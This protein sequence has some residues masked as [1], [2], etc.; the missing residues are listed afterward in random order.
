MRKIFDKNGANNGIADDY[1]GGAQIL[2]NELIVGRDYMIKTVGD[3]DWAAVGATEIDSNAFFTCTAV[4]SGTGKARTADGMTMRMQKLRQKNSNNTTDSTAYPQY[5]SWIDDR[6]LTSSRGTLM[7]T[8][9]AFKDYFVDDGDNIT[10]YKM[11]E[12]PMLRASLSLQSDDISSTDVLDPLSINYATS[13][14]YLDRDIVTLNTFNNSYAA[15]DNHNYYVKK[16]D[17]DTIQLSN[18]STLTDLVGFD[19][20]AKSNTYIDVYNFEGNEFDG[21]IALGLHD[22]EFVSDGDG[23]TITN[24]TKNGGGIEDTLYYIKTT[25]WKPKRVFLYTDQALT[26]LVL[27]DDLVWDTNYI[28]NYDPKLIY[29]DAGR[30][31]FNTKLKDNELSFNNT[32][33][34]DDGDGNTLLVADTI[35]YLKLVDEEVLNFPSNLLSLVASDYGTETSTTNYS[36]LLSKFGWLG[37]FARFEY[38]IYHDLELTNQVDLAVGTT[39]GQS[40]VDTSVYPI[41]LTYQEGLGDSTTINIIDIAHNGTNLID[42]TVYTSSTNTAGVYDLYKDINLTNALE[43]SDITEHNH[44]AKSLLFFSW[45]SSGYTGNIQYSTYDDEFIGYDT[46]SYFHDVIDKDTPFLFKST[47][48]TSKIDNQHI[49]TAGFLTTDTSYYLDDSNIYTDVG[50]TTLIDNTVLDQQIKITG[51]YDPRITTGFAHIDKRVLADNADNRFPN[52]GTITDPTHFTLSGE[53]T[54]ESWLDLMFDTW[55]ISIGHREPSDIVGELLVRPA[56]GHGWF[57]WTDAFT[58]Q[59]DNNPHKNF[60]ALHPVTETNKWEYKAYSPSLGTGI[61]DIWHTITDSLSLFDHIPTELGIVDVDADRIEDGYDIINNDAD[62]EINTMYKFWITDAYKGTYHWPY[63]NRIYGIK[64]NA[65]GNYLDG[66]SPWIFFDMI[67]HEYTSY[68]NPYDLTSYNTELWHQNAVLGTGRMDTDHTSPIYGEVLEQPQ[69]L[70]WKK[71][72]K[73]DYAIDDTDTFIGSKS[74]NDFAFTW[75]KYKSNSKT[76]TTPTALSGEPTNSDYVL[77]S[78]DSNYPT[79]DKFGSPFIYIPSD[80]KWAG[81]H[82]VDYKVVAT[83]TTDGTYAYATVNVGDE[84]GDSRP[85]HPDYPNTSAIA[86]TISEDASFDIDLHPNLWNE[87]EIYPRYYQDPTTLPSRVND[88]YWSQPKSLQKVTVDNVDCYLI[89]SNIPDDHTAT[90]PGF[91]MTLKYYV[92]DT[93]KTEDIAVNRFMLLPIEQFDVGEDLDNV[94]YYYWWNESPRTYNL[95]KMLDVAQNNS[96][97]TDLNIAKIENTITFHNEHINNGVT[98]SRTGWVDLEGD[99]QIPLDIGFTSVLNSHEL[100]DTTISTTATTSDPALFAPRDP[101]KVDTA[102]TFYPAT[103]GSTYLRDFAYK[104]DTIE[105]VSPGNTKYSHLNSSNVETVGAQIDQDHYWKHWTS[106]I[107]SYHDTAPDIDITLNSNG[108]ITGATHNSSTDAARFPQPWDVLFPIE[109]LDDEYTTPALTTSAL[110]DVWDTEDQWTDQGYDKTKYWP[111]HV[112]PASAEVTMDQPSS[113]TM[114]QSG[115]KYVKSAGFTKW[116]IALDYPPMSK[117]DFAPFNAVVQAVRGQYTPLYLKLKYNGSNILF[118][119]G[120]DNSTTKP[121]I[122]RSPYEDDNKVLFVEGFESNE[123][124]V[125]KQGEVIITGQDNGSIQTALHDVKSN[126]FGEAKVR[127]AY[128]SDSIKDV[129]KYIYKNPSSA[130]VTLA[131]DS[132]TYSVDTAGFYRIRVKFTLDDWK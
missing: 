69:L 89:P 68:E 72:I 121:R 58:S 75:P 52:W 76:L 25:P 131:Q 60:V 118:N 43:L 101:G 5:K 48:T 57:N 14:G 104:V 83:T 3:T 85:W 96:T 119:F 1:L 13:H 47:D 21:G 128:P 61:A 6:D 36:T 114:S 12:Q 107:K 123:E 127:L 30:V 22:H 79:V 92:D 35:Y 97:L 129:G 17:D 110:E 109:S 132:F 41:T 64:T 84:L 55:D 11:W 78:D 65:N 24:A 103:S 94:D 93:L 50:T 70:S 81:S 15:L 71:P 125:F 8:V 59:A 126:A 74:L 19:T 7:D 95:Y 99:E 44:K 117:D 37:A 88:M 53:Y 42:T 77:A 54:N 67:D 49:A 27:H 62:Y 124:N 91:M 130:V 80:T 29:A 34:I 108:Y 10:T 116:E 66:K 20:T 28:M 40:T 31:S 16:I 2:P 9:S 39:I 120:D 18:N 32:A 90:K 4:G 86:H 100:G 56:V 51:C 38:D 111:D 106:N 115:T 45:T 73:V 87:Y 102:M 23:V 46:H 63:R 105:V 26:D 33:D 98:H 113:V 122:A 112:V 82:I